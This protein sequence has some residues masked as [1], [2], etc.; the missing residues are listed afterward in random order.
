VEIYALD[1]LRSYGISE[2]IRPASEEMALHFSLLDR[3]TAW[4][5]HLRGICAQV[6]ASDLPK[7]DLIAF[8]MWTMACYNAIND[9][10]GWPC[11]CEYGAIYEPGYRSST[12]NRN[13]I[14]PLSAG[15]N[16][17]HQLL[18]KNSSRLVGS[19]FPGNRMP[20][21]YGSYIARS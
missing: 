7:S 2:E 15:V 10:R 11:L 20:E 16:A 6:I 4:A 19:G 9:F 14:E 12:K 18:S 5:G 1:A 8:Y 13:L 21:R 17:S 3:K